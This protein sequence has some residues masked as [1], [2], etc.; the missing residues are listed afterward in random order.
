ML[1]RCQSKRIRVK[2][3]L[4]VKNNIKYILIYLLLLIYLPFLMKCMQFLNSMSFST[5]KSCATYFLDTNDLTIL[6][7]VLKRTAC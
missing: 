7:T 6:L 1:Q 2:L 3:Y 5:V 4:K